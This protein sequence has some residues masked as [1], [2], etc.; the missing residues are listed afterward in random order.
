MDNQT[1]IT[2]VTSLEMFTW[3]QTWLL[4]AAIFAAVEIFILPAL[5]FVFAALGAIVTALLIHYGV[6]EATPLMAFSAFFGVTVVS[7]AALWKWLK[8]LYAGRGT[9][10]D[11]VGSTAEV[12]DTPLAKGKKGSVRWSGTTMQAILAEDADV[13]SLD[14]G[15]SVTIIAVTGTTL[16]VKP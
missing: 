6:I 15:T 8:S 9:Y 12:I 3:P 10:T 4:L 14:I 16:T 7:A 11:I 1:F 2:A 5:G 13:K